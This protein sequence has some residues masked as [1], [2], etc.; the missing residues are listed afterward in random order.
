MKVNGKLTV[1]CRCEPL[2]AR[3]H[4]LVRGVP[5]ASLVRTADPN[6]TCAKH[7]HDDPFSRV[8]K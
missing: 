2:H 4:R 6:L 5:W 1:A 3:W 8:K 7:K